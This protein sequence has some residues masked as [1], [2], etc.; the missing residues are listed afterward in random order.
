MLVLPEKATLPSRSM[1]M[2]MATCWPGFM[3]RLEHHARAKR[4]GACVDLGLGEI[5][6][7]FAF[8]VAAAHIVADGV[9]DDLPAGVITRASSGS[10]T[11]QVRVP[12]DADWVVPCPTTHGAEALKNSSGRRAV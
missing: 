4:T 1:R 6:R 7:V 12:A 11:F 3:E 5:E 9:A 8:D 2:R 10:G